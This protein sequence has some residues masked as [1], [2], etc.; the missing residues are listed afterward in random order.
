MKPEVKEVLSHDVIA[1]CEKKG[2][3]GIGMIAEAFAFNLR[4][5][6]ILKREGD[7]YF[8]IADKELKQKLLDHGFALALKSLIYAGEN[9]PK[10]DV[11]CV[12]WNQDL[13]M[14]VSVDT[15]EGRFNSGYAHFCYSGDMSAMNGCSGGPWGK[16]GACYNRDIREG[17]FSWLEHAKA[18]GR[19][20]NPWIGSHSMF[21]LTNWGDNYGQ[22][23]EWAR[24]RLL[25]QCIKDC[26]GA[27]DEEKVQEAAVEAETGKA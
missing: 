20:H 10:G 23:G 15:Y 3:E 5:G 24:L 26:I 12:Y 17:F 11:Q 14:V 19:F 13:G 7:T 22:D 1:D 16:P 8:G 6:D 4:K 2:V 25:P 18:S 27:N 9:W 21:R